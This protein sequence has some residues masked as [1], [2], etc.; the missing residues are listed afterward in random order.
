MR[1]LFSVLILIG[2]AIN[3]VAQ[4]K[5]VIKGTV[6]GDLKGYNKVYVFRED[7]YQDSVEIKN[8]R[9]TI[10]MPWVKD[11]MPYIHSEYDNKTRKG[12]AAFPLVIDAPGTVYIDV[13]DVTKGLRSGKI[14]GNRSATA[15]QAF[16]E[17]REKVRLEMKAAV[18]EHFHGDHPI[19]SAYNAVFQEKVKTML[20]PY[21]CNFVETNAGSYIGAFIL[22]RY[23]TVIPSDDLQRLYNKLGKLQKRTAP[24]E[25]VNARLIGLTRAVAGFEVLDFTLNSP[26][27]KPT[28]FSSLRGKYVLIDFWSSWCGP[29]KASFPH[30][31]ELYQ[32]YRGDEFEILGISI[33]QD[34]KAWLNELKKQQLPWPQVLDTKNVSVNSF[35]VTA[36]PT[37]YL[38]GPDGKIIMK[39]VGFGEEGDGEIEIKLKELFGK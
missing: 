39:Q 29:C 35:A 6:K 10:T 16:E 22:G 14:R 28:T 21:I 34:K 3:S 4:S 1:K 30:M 9:F 27:D 13:E 18:T 15:F 8:G 17:G 32:K 5:I 25:E 31:K 20:I 36:V 11:G 23:Q 37:A 2:V 7:E 38:I 12:P 24:A 26:E 33:D 19:D